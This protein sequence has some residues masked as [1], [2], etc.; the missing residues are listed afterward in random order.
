ME[1]EDGYEEKKAC[2]KDSGCDHVRI[3]LH[4]GE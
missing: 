1:L 3:G 2:S 4:F